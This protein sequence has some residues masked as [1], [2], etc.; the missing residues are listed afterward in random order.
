MKNIRLLFLL[1]LI[2]VFLA[3]IYWIFH[4]NT[5]NSYDL[6]ENKIAI[7]QMDNQDSKCPNMLIQKGSVLLLY[8]SNKPIDDS[9]PIPFANL[10][11][12]IFYVI[13][14]TTLFPIIFDDFIF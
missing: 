5:K 8:N 13:N 1:F 14:T 7:E 3:G 6:F 4:F 10:D 2:I 9:N 12:Y 11:E